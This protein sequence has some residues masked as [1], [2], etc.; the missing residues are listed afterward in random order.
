MSKSITKVAGIDIGK[1]W[2]DVALYPET[3]CFRVENGAAG[4]RRLVDRLR[5]AGVGRVA[6]EASGGYER[7]VAGALRDAGLEVALLQPRQVRAYAAWRLRRAKNDVLDARLLACVA[8]EL[9]SV[10][11]APDARLAPLGEHLRF[12]EQIEADLVRL[13]TRLESFRVPRLKTALLREVRRLERHKEAEMARLVGEVLAHD[14]LRRRLELI[15]SIPGIGRRTALALVLLMPELGRLDRAEIACLAGLAP[16]DHDSGRH[17]GKRR[18]AGGRGRVR[19]AL[20]MAAFA[21]SSRWNPAL[22]DLYTRLR[23]NGKPH[24]QAVIACARKLLI[25][26]NTVLERQTP[27]QNTPPHPNG[28]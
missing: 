8:A 10:R 17:A 20:F 13:K 27:W 6:M 12:I 5:D 26:A 24:K 25:F 21:A 28:C 4:W 16:F 11:P 15:E 14:D 7:G 22:K 18:I 2:L 1:A 23:Q 3:T 19:R 9:E